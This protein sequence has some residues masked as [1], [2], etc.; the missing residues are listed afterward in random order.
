LKPFIKAIDV[1]DV[2]RPAA[3]KFQ[4]NF[5]SLGKGICKLGKLRKKF[6]QIYTRGSSY[7][8]GWKSFWSFL[9]SEK[10]FDRNPSDE[11]GEKNG[12]WSKYFIQ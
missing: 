12:R 7:F 1:P 8:I 5:S 3:M 6:C 10:F 11:R 9:L 4:K 2:P